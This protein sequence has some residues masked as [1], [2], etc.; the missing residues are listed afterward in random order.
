L[1][2]TLVTHYF[3]CDGYLEA[4][5]LGVGGYAINSLSLLMGQNGYLYNVNNYFCR[6][7]YPPKGTPKIC[8]RI[9]DL[10][11]DKVCRLGFANLSIWL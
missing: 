7:C 11:E 3:G 6:E 2:T 5:L 4:H 9:S 8:W 1:H 10:G